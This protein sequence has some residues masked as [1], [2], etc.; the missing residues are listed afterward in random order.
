M[1]EKIYDFI[2]IYCNCTN[3][4][5]VI[6]FSLTVLFIAWLI[7][8]GEK[9]GS[10]KKINEILHDETDIDI[11]K[12]IES[13]K[14]SKRYRKM[15]DEYYFAYKNEETVALD[16]YLVKSGML[17]E[18][19][20]VRYASVTLATGLFSIAFFAMFKIYALPFF[21]RTNLMI[22]FFITVALT[23]F[24]DFLY[25]TIGV[26]RKKKLAELLEEF[27]T[28]SLRKLSGSASSFEQ[29]K[30][31]SRLDRLNCAVDEL[32]LS[33]EVINRRTDGLYTLLAQA[34]EEEQ[35]TDEDDNK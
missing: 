35:P 21:E 3:F 28:L 32:R 13:L 17:I 19:K 29:Q 16:N 23:V 20:A 4:A 33:C 22:L 10:L 1:L 15:W 30:I 26:I 25:Y 2:L 27:H 11:I 8:G 24:F 6:A 9:I 14:L 18:S 34:L 7:F 12:K 31:A 5:V